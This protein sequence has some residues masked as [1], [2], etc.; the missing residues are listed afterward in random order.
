MPESDELMQ[1]P[2][3]Q[4]PV[5]QQPVHENAAMQ[6]AQQEWEQRTQELAP[7]LQSQR[8]ILGVNVKDS[9]EMQQVKQSLHAL[10]RALDIPLG[11][12]A[13]GDAE[14]VLDCYHTAIAAC[15]HYI[16]VKGQPR[17]EQGR[18]RLHMVQ[19]ILPKLRLE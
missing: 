14:K 16:T 8:S 6:A 10:N 18:V 1:Q 15:R 11:A 12:F 9:A 5:Q 2:V 17:T 19:Q 13:S 7:L 3:Q 4:Q